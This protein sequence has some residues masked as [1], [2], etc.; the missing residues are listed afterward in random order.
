MRENSRRIHSFL[1][2]WVQRSLG[3][4]ITSEPRNLRLTSCCQ[5][6]RSLTL[7]LYKSPYSPSGKHSSPSLHYTA[8]HGDTH[9]N[10]TRPKWLPPVH[11]QHLPSRLPHVRTA[12]DTHA[13]RL[14]PLQP[15]TPRRHPPTTDQRSLRRESPREQSL[16]GRHCRPGELREEMREL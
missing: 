14:A 8:Q 13:E 3:S 11:L 5:Y 6:S 1:P 4:L 12:A 15:Q 10:S 16:A 7:A 2:H 9:A